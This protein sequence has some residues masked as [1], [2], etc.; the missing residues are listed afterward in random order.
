VKIVDVCEF[1][2]PTGRRPCGARYINQKL[3]LAGK[4]GPRTGRSLRQAAETR[5][6]AAPAALR[7]D[8]ESPPALRPQLPDVLESPGSVADLDPGDS[9]RRV[10][11]SMRVSAPGA[12]IVSSWPNFPASASFWL[13]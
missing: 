11:A 13:I 7:L 8:Q 5:M 10:P 6:E 9:A 1:Y 2:S 12:M 4:F 3:A